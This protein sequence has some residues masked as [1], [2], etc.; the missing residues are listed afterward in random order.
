MIKLQFAFPVILY[1]WGHMSL[2][3]LMKSTFI[4]AVWHKCSKRKYF[5]LYVFYQCIQ[6]FYNTLE[7]NLPEWR[8]AHTNIEKHE[9]LSLVQIVLVSHTHT[10]FSNLCQR[11][12]HRIFFTLFYMY[13][14]SLSRACSNLA[15]TGIKLKLSEIVSGRN[16]CKRILFR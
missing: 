7:H 11:F 13:Q 16:K 6:N 4:N 5:G 3:I 9:A 12:V 8:N 14:C 1:S 15:C 10:T 2:L